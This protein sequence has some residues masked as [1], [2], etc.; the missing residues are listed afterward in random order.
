MRRNTS[1][2]RRDVE[3]RADL[4]ECKRGTAAARARSGCEDDM[5]GGVA[6]SVGSGGK[7]QRLGAKSEGSERAGATVAWEYDIRPTMAVSISRSYMAIP[8]GRESTHW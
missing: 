1:V 7:G 3:T 5:G 8:A 4:E 6:A 2:R